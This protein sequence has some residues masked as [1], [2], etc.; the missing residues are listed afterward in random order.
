[1]KMA[2][3][4]AVDASSAPHTWIVP[5]SEAASPSHFQGLVVLHVLVAIG[6]VIGTFVQ[7]IVVARA[8]RREPA[9]RALVWSMR[10]PGPL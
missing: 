3:V 6:L 2:T 7:A 10:L 1:M 5:R 9:S 4:V 8:N